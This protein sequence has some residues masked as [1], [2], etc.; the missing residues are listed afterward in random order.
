MFIACHDSCTPGVKVCVHR[1]VVRCGSVCVFI[2]CDVMMWKC[3][4][5]ADVC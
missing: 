4:F 1:C 2:A 3:V 5:I